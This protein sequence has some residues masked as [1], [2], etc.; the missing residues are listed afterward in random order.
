[1]R[2]NAREPESMSQLT[3]TLVSSCLFIDACVVRRDFI[4]S[5]LAT[6][7]PASAAISFAAHHLVME[8][9]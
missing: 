7:D 8:L 2:Q 1:M 9:S 3:I 6:P 5:Y 4:A